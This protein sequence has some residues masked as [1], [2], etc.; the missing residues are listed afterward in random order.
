MKPDISP[1]RALAEFFGRIPRASERQMDEAYP[2]I[3]NRIALGSPAAADA[4]G[5]ERPR[6]QR[7]SYRATRAASVAA[8][9]LLVTGVGYRELLNRR[10]ATPTTL[11]VVSGN[12]QR[13]VDEAP[14]AVGARVDGGETA[15]S[16]DG[17]VI[18]LADGSRLE[19]RPR[20]E[21][22]LEAADDGTR[23]RLN[24]GSVIVTAAK[25]RTGHLYVQTR[26]VTVSVVGTVFL[27]NAED[28]GSRVAVIQG[29]VRVVEQRG[30][31]RSLRPGEQVATSPLMEPHFV[32]EQ[33]SWSRHAEEHLALLQQATIAPGPAVPLRFDAASIKPVSGWAPMGLACRGSDGLWSSPFTNGPSA[34][35]DPSSYPMVVPQGRCVGRGVRVSSLIAFAY[36]IPSEYVSGVP[37]WDR[38]TPGG[39]GG[40]EIEAAAENPATVTREQ[41]RQMLQ[42]L[43]ADRFR[44]ALHREF[45]D[46]QGYALLVGKRGA[47]LKEAA[48]Q[49]GSSPWVFIRDGRRVLKGRSVLSELARYLGSNIHSID[50]AGGI[51]HVAVV[52]KTQ[53]GGMYDYELVLPSIG[54]P[55]GARGDGAAPGGLPPETDAASMLSAAL[56]EQLGLRLQKER[57][58]IEALVID[59]VEPPS[60]N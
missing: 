2:R 32:S 1:G 43:L 39:P 28:A 4:V 60:P 23:I 52:D 55:G 58:S 48:G 50:L 7:R 57:V 24:R 31:S 37:G 33:I 42:T 45:R 9:L 12:V 17:G 59:H 22:R 3:W 47:K 40:Y 56:E 27:V 38:P 20:T 6:L 15:F 21:V 54:A 16:Q 46:G 11:E 49:E 29:E 34:N 5:H 26:D 53:L 36:G 44:L 30:T 13:F 18:A 10:P 19:M 41:L 35:A 51:E 8:V 25:R 14:I